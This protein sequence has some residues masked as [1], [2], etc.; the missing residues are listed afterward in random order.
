MLFVMEFITMISTPG[1][2]WASRIP[3]SY[4][5]GIYAL[6]EAPSVGNRAA[7]QGSDDGA[8]QLELSLT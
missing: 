3:W 2:A 5:E 8:E 4:M 6:G 1:V 7:V